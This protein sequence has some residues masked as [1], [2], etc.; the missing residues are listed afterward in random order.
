LIKYAK[1]QLGDVFNKLTTSSGLVSR[2]GH[3]YADV[4]FSC[5]D[6]TPENYIGIQVTAMPSVDILPPHFIN[7]KT[8][9]L[10]NNNYDCWEKG[11]LKGTYTTLKGCPSYM[12][13][14]HTKESQRGYILDAVLYP[15]INDGVEVYY[16]DELIAVHKS[17]SDLL[18]R[19]NDRSIAVSIGAD[20]KYSICSRCGQIIRDDSDYCEH[21]SMGKKGNQ[22]NLKGYNKPTVASE[23]CGHRDDPDSNRFFETSWVVVPAFRSAAIQHIFGSLTKL[24]SVLSKEHS[25]IQKLFGKV[26][27]ASG[28]SM[29]IQRLSLKLCSSPKLASSLLFMSDIRKMNPIGFNLGLESLVGSYET[30]QINEALTMVEGLLKV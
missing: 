12:E 22:F 29:N 4:D 6:D 14:N 10:V 30:K 11:L 26:K 27:V 21:V 23:I 5:L 17:F 8:A 28:N 24:S 16:V 3:K 2:T 1:A 7:P 25:D 15:V 13:H 18:Q 9:N 19:I 20:V